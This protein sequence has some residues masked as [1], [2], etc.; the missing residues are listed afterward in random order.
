MKIRVN[1]REYKHSDE[2][3]MWSMIGGYI[4]GYA[5]FVILLFGYLINSI[6]K[7]AF[8]GRDLILVTIVLASAI[9]FGICFLCGRMERKC[10]ERDIP[11]FQPE[12]ELT[13]EQIKERIEMILKN[14]K[15]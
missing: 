14:R 13:E 5:F 1:Y 15:A 3:S 7:A 2:A 11:Q 12:K 4:G 9:T 6:L 10:A 8:P